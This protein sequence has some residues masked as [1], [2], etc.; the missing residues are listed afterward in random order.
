VFLGPGTY[1]ELCHDVALDA[2]T[3]KGLTQTVLPQRERGAE[4]GRDAPV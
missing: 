3:L 4:G 2:R 1:S